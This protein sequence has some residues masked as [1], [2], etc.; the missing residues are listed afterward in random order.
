[1]ARRNKEEHLTLSVDELSALVG[2][3]SRRVRQIDKEL[4]ELEDGYPLL[5]KAEDG[6]YDAA[7]FVQAWVKYKAGGER[8]ESLD[9]VRAAHEELKLRMTEIKLKQASSELIRVSD[10]LRVWGDVAGAFKSKLLSLPTK[11]ALRLVHIED[12]EEARS[13][14]DDEVR[15]LLEELTSGENIEKMAGKVDRDEGE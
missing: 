1:M 8:T 2:L 11:L 4:Q 10:V 5:V 12:P 6:R 15:G 3:G 14:L 13:I 7:S 9:K